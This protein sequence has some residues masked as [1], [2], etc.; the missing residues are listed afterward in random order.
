MLTL[1]LIKLKVVLEQFVPPLSSDRIGSLDDIVYNRKFST[2]QNKRH[3][4]DG[5]PLKLFRR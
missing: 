2:A 4:K 5:G 3:E 1:N